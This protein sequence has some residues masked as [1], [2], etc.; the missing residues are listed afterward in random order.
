MKMNRKSNLDE[1]QEQELLKIEHNGCWLAFWLLLA[2]LVV[3]SVVYGN[4]DFRTLAGEWIVFM[5]LAVYL[6]IACVRKGIWDRK[7]QMNTKT[8]LVASL[9]A[10]AVIGIFNAFMIYRVYQKPVGTAAA[11]LITAV[12]T[13][14]ITFAVLSFAM[15]MTIQRK[16][17]ME[18]E[19]S[20]AD[21]M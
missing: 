9:I 13:F 21:E 15:K 1:M 14:A 12:I 3:Q 18:A 5:V 2:S 7:L 4:M 6:A 10:A 17:A 20:D 16:A 19:P 11:A 8:N